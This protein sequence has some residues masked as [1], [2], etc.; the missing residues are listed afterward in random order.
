[1]RALKWS[2]N[3]YRAMAG[4]V[5]TKS[6]LLGSTLLVILFW[7]ITG[8]IPQ[9]PT[10]HDF[11]DQRSW[12][13]ISNSLDV[14]TNIL[15]CLVGLLGLAALHHNRQIESPVFRMYLTFF[16][17][18]FLTGL[19]SIYYHLNPSDST[20]VWDRLPLSIALMSF[21]SLVFS[22]RVN[23][24]L[25]QKL[26]PWLVLAGV[27]S[28]I[29]WFWLDD[30]RLYILVQF[31][32]IMVLPFILWCYKGSNSGVLWAALNFYAAAKIFEYM[33]QQIYQYSTELISGHSLKHIAASLSTFMVVVKL[34]LEAN[35]R[36]A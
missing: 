27:C 18:V 26:F 15:F 33:D 17:S 9:S 30:L 36:H 31:G 8:P 35:D 24:E 28:V 3:Q 19:G 13:E 23:L 29:Y 25:G 21:L 4:K 11:A 14:L 20:L 6:L 2:L 7:W 16:I 10:Y 12:F 22:E 1:M 34:S 32:S 5:A